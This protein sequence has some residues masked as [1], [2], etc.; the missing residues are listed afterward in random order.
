MKKTITKIIMLALIGLSTISNGQAPNWIWAQ[1]AGA[2]GNCTT[3]ASGNVYV[4]GGYSSST[5][6]FGTDTLTNAGGN[7]ILLV[8]YDASGNVIWAK[9]AGGTGDDLCMNITSDASGN[10]YLTG[11]YKSASIIFGADTLINASA[12]NEDIFIAKYDASGNAIWAMGAGGSS[13]DW[14]VSIAVDGS[15]SSYVVG[16]FMS[17]SITFGTTTLTR[18]GWIDF[19]L[20]KYDASGNVLWAK[21][22]DAGGTGGDNL[23]SVAVDTSGNA[24]ITGSFESSSITFGTTTFTNSG[25][26]F[27]II[28][29]VKYDGNGNVL[30]AKSSGGNASGACV[31]TDASGNVFV[32]GHFVSPTVIFGSIIL[33]N[34]NW[35][36]N[37]MFI[38]KF[39]ASGNPLWARSAGGTWNEYG[40]SVTT[41]A[42]GNVY[43]AGQYNSS[44]ITFGA[45]TLTNAASS[46]TNDIFI[47]KYSA[48]G[49]VLWAIGAGSFSNDN[50]NSISANAFGNVYVAGGYDSTSITLGAIILTNSFGSNMFIGKLGTT[51]GIAD[52]T[53]NN[54]V[55]VF[56]NPATN[57]LTI[58][59]GS[60][61]KKVE[62]TIADITGKIIYTTISTDTENVEVN[63]KDFAAGI[64]VVQIQSADF[65]ATKKL[66]I[67]K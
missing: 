23:W 30:W 44:S 38:V 27:P 65:T 37:D 46:M 60:N 32:T 41:D 13:T 17:P 43:V 22:Q 64:Y 20:V 11:Y 5:I 6:I 50:I 15:G 8:K 19:F 1:S 18:L 25:N 9:S 54:E 61:N 12:G 7:D 57:H 48:S 14:A 55:S 26:L 29:I 4:S 56:P 2:G 36:Q 62:V 59:L 53:F 66:V 63:T 47:V 24:V 49:N 51:T 39:N 3:D 21:K 67:E 40:N 28:Y 31:A 58:A 16:H 35:P 33:N 45:T 42:S 34:S 10:V 52:N